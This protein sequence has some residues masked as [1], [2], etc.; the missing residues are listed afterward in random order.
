M[1]DS[2]AINLGTSRRNRRC[3][4]GEIR[5][6]AARANAEREAIATATIVKVNAEAARKARVLNRKIAPS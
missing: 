3:C 4:E 1:S 6:V 2:L 5:E